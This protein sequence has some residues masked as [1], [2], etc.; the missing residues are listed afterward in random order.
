MICNPRFELERIK[1]MTSDGLVTNTSSYID[2]SKTFQK[3][4]KITQNILT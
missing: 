2:V 4:R 3:S 1:T